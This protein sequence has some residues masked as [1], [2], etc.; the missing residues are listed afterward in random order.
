MSQL[1]D[2][3]KAQTATFFQKVFNDGDMDIIDAM[4]GPDY[5]FNG[6]PTTADQTKQWAQGLRKRFPDI[7]FSIEAMLG[8][9]EKVA[10]RWRMLGT[11]ATSG[12]QLTATGTNILVIVDGK[13]SSNDQGGGDV[14]SPVA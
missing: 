1:S 8:E 6:Q 12:K 2:R 7:H 3:N 9:D 5:E 14:F 10:L 13:A 11:D 4:I